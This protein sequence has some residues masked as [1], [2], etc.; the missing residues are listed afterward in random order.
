MKAVIPPPLVLL[1]CGALMW[2]TQKYFPRLRFDL[3][4]E[5]V[6]FWVV[7]VI[8]FWVLASGVGR[9]FRNK[10]AIHPNREALSKATTLVTT[11]VFRYT[12]NPIYLGMAVMLVAWL[13]LLEHWLCAAGPLLFVAFITKYQILPEEEA[14]GKIFGEEYFRYRSET[15]RWM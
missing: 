8:G 10:T 11:G 5:T 12:R 3:P 13:L 1:F 6:L 4:Y 9:I 2:V 7:L 15:R 14:L